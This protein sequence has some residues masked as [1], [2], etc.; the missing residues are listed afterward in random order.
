MA[1]KKNRTIAF[2]AAA[3]STSGSV[4]F[5]LPFI[6]E[7]KI[8]P[9]DPDSAR[10]LKSLSPPLGSD[11][12]CLITRS[13]AEPPAEGCIEP[14]A[15]SGGCTLVRFS[16]AALPSAFRT[17][18]RFRTLWIMPT[19]RIR[20]SH[21]RR[22]SSGPDQTGGADGRGR[23]CAAKRAN[24]FELSTATLHKNLTVP[25]FTRNSI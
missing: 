3:S 11:V 8:T 24:G 13:S 21:D 25:R 23:V 16:R 20:S 15:G 12:P 17:A 19:T 14:A 10:S 9:R 6:L 2:S 18:P 7:E 1:E 22:W 5:T 4:Q